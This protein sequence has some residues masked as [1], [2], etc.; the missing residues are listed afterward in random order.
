[1]RVRESGEAEL[2]KGMARGKSE[3]DREEKVKGSG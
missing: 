3:E 2:R 1:M